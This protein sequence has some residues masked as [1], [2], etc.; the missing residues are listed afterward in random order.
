MHGTSRA[1]PVVLVVALVELA[2][3]TIRAD[4]PGLRATLSCAPAGEPGRVRCDVEVHAPTGQIRWA[5]A[6]LASV[7]ELV[8][9]LKGRIGPHDATTKEATLW[10]LP[11]ALVAKRSGAG[12]V[13]SRV[14]AVV[15][16]GE[17]DQESCI[18]LVA[19]AR[20][21]VKVGQ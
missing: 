19:E 1:A 16:T 13:V 9:P 17:A 8:A 5:D 7:P 3:S 11:F 21:D 10:R 15:C 18:P 12:S 2:Q 6:E 20:G 14:R 4:P